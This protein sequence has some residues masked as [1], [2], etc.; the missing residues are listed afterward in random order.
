MRS[1][2]EVAIRRKADWFAVYSH[3]SGFSIPLRGL[4]MRLFNVFSFY[5]LG[6]CLGALRVIGSLEG[7]EA[8]E[9]LISAMMQL[10]KLRQEGIVSLEAVHLKAD[11]INTLIV[12]AMEQVSGDALR[13]SGEQS[14]TLSKRLSEFET[15]LE[16]QMPFEH[17]YTIE[18]LRGFMMPILVDG[19]DQNFSEKT[20][21]AIGEEVKRD[22][23]E[24]GADS[25]E[26]GH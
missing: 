19:A 25:D 7:P 10:D 5:K 22:I 2:Q 23:R 3:A 16:A 24:A 4:K 14:E 1:E 18:Q 12:D 17:T 20:I 13:V 6:A 26:G 11:G 9:V 15:I 21:K 8:L